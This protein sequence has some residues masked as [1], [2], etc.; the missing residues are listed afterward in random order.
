M[1]NKAL[2]NIGSMKDLMFRPPDEEPPLPIE[3]FE[4]IVIQTID[5][6]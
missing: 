3:E 5:K 6:L 4:K 2:D 1:E